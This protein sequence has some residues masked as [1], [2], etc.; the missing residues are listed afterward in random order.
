MACF[1]R[2]TPFTYALIK[3]HLAEYALG[4]GIWRSHIQYNNTFS[5]LSNKPKNESLY[6]LEIGSGDCIQFM[7]K[8]ICDYNDINILLTDIDTQV[9]NKGYQNIIDYGFNKKNI[10]SSYLD[11]TNSENVQ[12]T[13]SDYFNQQ[14]T[15]NKYFDSIGISAVIHCIEG[16]IN[17]KVPRIL[18]NLAPFMSKDTILFGFT[19]TNE[20]G[21]NIIGEML[22]RMII[23]PTFNYAFDKDTQTDLEGVFFQYFNEYNINK[24]KTTMYFDAT[25]AVRV[26]SDQNA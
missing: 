9:L 6:H 13:L 10:R 11:I 18:N 17:I 1:Q 15:T 3:K 5:I 25:N 7:D 26:S 21:D 4:A 8:K 2:M 22:L 23:R 24:S 14:N 12:T 20:K 16:S 19:A